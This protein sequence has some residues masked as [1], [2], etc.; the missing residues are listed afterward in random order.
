MTDVKFDDAF[1]AGYEVEVIESIPDDAF[2]FEGPGSTRS[3]GVVIKVA[4]EGGRR[5][6][7]VARAGGPSV[8]GALSGVFST[9]A[10]TRLLL[11]G[12]GDAFLVDVDAP[13]RFEA[14]DTGGPVV[15]VRPVAGEGL[16]LLASPWT[17]TAIGAD[18]VRWQ[19]GRLAIEGIRLDEVQAGQLAGVADPDDDEPRD[20]V[21]DLR[22]G[23][24]EGGVPF[25]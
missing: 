15:A 13:E 17:I 12:R 25:A 11:I 19:T 5:W 7:G 1:P 3:G 23:R 16:L 2:V 9:P 20:F 22:T 21:V 14:L 18:G 8:Q 4:T 24:H 10:K 6:V